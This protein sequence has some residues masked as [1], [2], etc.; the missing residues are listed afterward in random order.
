MASSESYSGEERRM[1]RR[2]R[3]F[4]SGR[5][6][7]NRG[8]GAFECVV[9]NRSTNGAMLAFGDTAAIPGKFEFEIT[10]EDRR[11]IASVRWRTMTGL[12]VSF[13]IA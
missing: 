10:G 7:F 1:E 2:Q 3:V 9:R 11:H 8:Y 4:K 6:R 5:V 13:G 12:G